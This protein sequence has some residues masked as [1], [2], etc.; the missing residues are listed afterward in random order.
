MQALLAGKDD[1]V[2]RLKKEKEHFK[3]AYEALLYEVRE[4]ELTFELMQRG[5][6]EKIALLAA[7][8]KQWQEKF[9]AISSQV[10]QHTQQSFLNLAQSTMEKMQEQAKGEWDKKEQTLHAS[11]LPV[12]EILGRFDQKLQEIE[13]MRVSS[14]AAMAQHMQLLQDA[15]QSL[16]TETGNL[17][18][19]LRVSNVRGRWGEIQ[20]KRVVELAGMVDHCDFFEQNSEDS[21]DGR[22]RPDMI[23]RLPGQ[24]NI[25]VDAKTPI[26]A[27]LEA[28]D[29]TDEDKKKSK[30]QEHARQLRSHVQ[31]LS[32][33]TY[34]EQFQPT[35][36][37]VILF[38]PGEPFF[39]A[40]LEQD[41]SLIEAGVEQ[42]VLIATPITLI[43]LLRA[44][45]FG[46][47]QT[48]LSEAAF[49]MGEQGKELYKRLIDMAE[50]WQRLGKSL[51]HSIV[52]YNKAVGS[53]ESRVLVAA[54]KFNEMEPMRH[55]L[56][57]PEVAPVEE[58][59]RQLNASEMALPE[60]T[61]S[62]EK[63]I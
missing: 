22:Q 16:K 24:K 55:N 21:Q 51:G 6:E 32:R 52:A 33:K 41:P 17:A 58:Q 50:H 13:Q 49:K 5:S 8:E 12:K 1:E 34:W 44:V 48:H 62:H 26:N 59:P 15:H 40:A 47:R 56:Q 25:I 3:G 36:E 10:L 11:M 14:H 29:C 63:L 42:K 46:W 53:L 28:L 18:R 7:T 23:I 31:N 20:L 30:L 60:E 57:I 61:T 35:P 43:A 39:S 27:Y 37:F 45:A 2:D 38:L 19:A 9:Q 54:R 4:K